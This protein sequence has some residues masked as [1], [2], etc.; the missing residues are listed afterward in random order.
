MYLV[1][2]L[3][4]QRRGQEWWLEGA[5]KGEKGAQENT[6]G[7]CDEIA[8]VKKP[9]LGNRRDLYIL[10]THFIHSFIYPLFIKYLLVYSFK[11]IT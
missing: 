11:N 5:G 4:G 6:E 7:S 2:F 8:P 10:F 1:Y 3:P 9:A